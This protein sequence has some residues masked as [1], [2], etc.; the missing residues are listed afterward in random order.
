MGKVAQNSVKYVVEAELKSTGMVEKPDVVGAIFGQTE[1]LLGED[2]D[3]RE[4]QERGKVGRIDVKVNNRDGRSDAQI[5]IPS[6]LDAT[7]TALL[8]AALETIERVGPTDADITVKELRDERT[9]K[10]D[11]IVKRAK[12]LLDSL[13]D[14]KPGKTEITD[15]I[16]QEVRT[17]HISE[18]RGFKA[19]PEA[20]KSDEII[21]VEGRADVLNLLKH[22]VKNAVA[23]GGTSVPKKIQEIGEKKRTTAFLDGDRGGDLILKELKQ[24]AKPEFVTR[25]PENK[26]V[27]ELGKEDVYSALRDR[28]PVKYDKVEHVERKQIS[29]DTKEKLAERLEK[30]VGTRAIHVLDKDFETVDK[31]PYSKLGEKELS[32][33][34]AVVMDGEIDQK[35]VDSAEKAGAEFIVGMKRSGRANSS[36]LRILTRKDVNELKPK[37]K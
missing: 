12:Q 29:R 2:L 8:G 23:L 16:K 4:L 22:G 32:E 33:C 26:E 15:E 11:Y 1:G 25:A 30:L 20:E 13:E 3:L 34:K 24:K 36:S 6:S 28:S 19:G 14:N 9:S 21:L 17:G 7:E 35:Q 10:R 27:E 31:L 5:E 18:Y 37:S